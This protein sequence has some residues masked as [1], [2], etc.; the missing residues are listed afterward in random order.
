MEKR[1]KQKKKTLPSYPKGMRSE[2]N[3]IHVM[4]TLIA[5]IRFF[6]CLGAF[7]TTMVSILSF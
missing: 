5:A 1:N 4:N 7:G 6:S 2:D 3:I